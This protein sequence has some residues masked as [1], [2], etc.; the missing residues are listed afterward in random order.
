MNEKMNKER[1]VLAELKNLG[2]I[3]RNLSDANEMSADIDSSKRAN[4]DPWFLQLFFGFSG[5]LASLF[6][7][8]FYHSYYGKP[9]FLTV[10]SVHLLSAYY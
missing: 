8:G 3:D 4:D 9:M 1:Q 5:V 6:S 10:R 7:L 2:V